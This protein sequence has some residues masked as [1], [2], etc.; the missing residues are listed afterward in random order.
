MLPQRFRHIAIEGPIGVGKSSLA[1]RLAEP[2]GAR[3]FLEQPQDNPYLERFYRAGT[4]DLQAN[5]YALPTQLFFLFQRLEQ[6]REL[7]QPGMFDERLVSDFLFAKDALFAR[8]TL[9]DEDHLLYTQIYRRYAPRV[10]QPDLVIWLRAEGPTLLQ[11]IARRGLAMEGGIAPD[12]LA[13]LSEGYVRL[14]SELPGVPV[15]AIDTDDFN[16]IDN[17]E[18]FEALVDRLAQFRG[19]RERWAPAALV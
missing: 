12:Y 16:P 7:A 9:A 19:P 6:M 8:L 13:R 3:L 18:H 14:F 15:L 11:R 17:E 1:R 4:D 2:L 10:P 5:P